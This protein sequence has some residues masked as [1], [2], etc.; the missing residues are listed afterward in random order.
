MQ[1]RWQTT[2]SR[3]FRGQGECLARCDRFSKRVYGHDALDF[4]LVA[5]CRASCPPVSDRAAG[6]P[7]RGKRAVVARGEAGAERAA[8]MGFAVWRAGTG[9]CEAR[10]GVR[11]VLNTAGRSAAFHARAEEGCFPVGMPG[12]QVCWAAQEFPSFAGALL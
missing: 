12:A 6:S 11:P 5:E 1:Q 9:F 3:L 2:M 10:H 4:L 8:R 7:Y